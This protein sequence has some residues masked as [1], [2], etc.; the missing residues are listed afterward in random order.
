MM[1]SQLSFR[2]IH[3]HTKKKGQLNKVG[4]CPDNIYLEE[5]KGFLKMGGEVDVHPISQISD[6]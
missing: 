5:F 4:S 1:P 3:T 2:Q 6:S